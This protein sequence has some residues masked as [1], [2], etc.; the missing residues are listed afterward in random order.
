M[1]LDMSKYL[2]IF[3]SEATEH[4]EALGR[5]LLQLEKKKGAEASEVIDSMFRHA[6]SVKGM[7]ASM[8]FDPIAMLAHRA[9][10]KLHAVRSEPAL[11]SQELVDKL[12]AA[13][14]ALLAQVRAA[15]EGKPF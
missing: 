1:T 2:G 10:D 13:T 12:L 7:A 9:E 8:G 11:L 4:L 3:V 15:S 6:H 14:D 5:D